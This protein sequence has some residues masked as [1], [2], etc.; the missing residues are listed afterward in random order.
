[1]NEMFPINQTAAA[2]LSLLALYYC[3]FSVNRTFVYWVYGIAAT[4][5]CWFLA[6]LF[7][8]WFMCTPVAKVWD[9][10][11]P[12]HCI[13]SNELMAVGEALNSVLDFVMIG[14]AVWIIQSLQVSAKNR[15]KLSFLFAMGGITGIVGFMKIGE[16]YGDIGTNILDTV[17]IVVQMAVS[18]ICCC[19]PIYRS[20]MPESP[21]LRRLWSKTVGSLIGGR[22][23][24]KGES[25]SGGSPPHF[26]PLRTFGQGSDRGNRRH[27]DLS[28]KTW[29]VEDWMLLDGNTST[30]EVHVGVG[31]TREQDVPGHHGCAVRTVQIQQTVEAV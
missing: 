1:M 2:K 24:N 9:P 22:S 25:S 14:L 6:M 3:L 27:D 11:M 5:I 13:N 8:R 15:W 23:S 4:Y 30:G 21:L 20:I 7:I 28:N 26:P 31:T 16:A 19:A 12:G 18:I 10:S 17:W 29:T